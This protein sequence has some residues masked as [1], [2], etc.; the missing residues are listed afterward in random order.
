MYEAQI[1]EMPSY[2]IGDE[3]SFDD[4]QMPHVQVC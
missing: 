1:G 4:N 3:R 2:D